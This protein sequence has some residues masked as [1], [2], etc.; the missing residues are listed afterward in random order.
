MSEDFAMGDAYKRLLSAVADLATAEGQ[1]TR[2]RQLQAA[3]MATDNDVAEAE[4]HRHKA[5]MAQNA[6]QAAYNDF[7]L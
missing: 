1:L 6:A 3:G 4:Q 2:L 5:Q 7:L